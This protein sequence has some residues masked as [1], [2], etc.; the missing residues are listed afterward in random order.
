MFNN[1]GLKKLNNA[2]YKKSIKEPGENGNDD[3]YIRG[4]AYT[5]E[6]HCTSE[7]VKLCSLKRI[8]LSHHCFRI[9]IPAFVK[10]ICATVILIQPGMETHHHQKKR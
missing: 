4:C 3:L 8:Y 5:D 2:A 7:L 1:W 6:Y 10:M 9:S